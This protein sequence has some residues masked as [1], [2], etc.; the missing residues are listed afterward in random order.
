MGFTIR[1]FIMPAIRLKWSSLLQ[2]TELEFSPEP[3]TTLKVSDEL[4]QAISWLTGAT[5]HDRRL[6]RC[7]ENGAL[8]VADAW[9]LFNSVETDELHPSSGSTDT[10]T[11]TVEHKGILIATSTELVKAS[12]RRLSG[13]ALENIYIPAETFYWFDHS[14]YTV[15]ISVVPDPAGT[16]SYVGVTAFN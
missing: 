1:G 12:F 9:S 5:R 4:L 10:Y 6:L 8:L 13:V 11:P 16:T 3:P 15:Q 14:C 7:D 2:L